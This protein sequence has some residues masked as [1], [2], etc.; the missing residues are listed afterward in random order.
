MWPAVAVQMNERARGGFDCRQVDVWVEVGVQLH[1]PTVLH[2]AEAP[3]LRRATMRPFFPG[4]DFFDPNFFPV[5]FLTVYLLV[6]KRLYVS[7]VLRME[8]MSSVL[9]L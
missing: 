7:V 6:F 8:R 4:H 9:T 1:A 5:W 3:L 2:V